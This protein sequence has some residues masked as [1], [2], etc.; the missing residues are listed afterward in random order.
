MTTRGFFKHFPP[1]AFLQMHA[2]G[3]DIADE[4][5]RFIDLVPAPKCLALR[6]YG[7]KKLPKGVV[8]SGYINDAKTLTAALLELK[9]EHNLS[10]VR[11]S[12]PEEKGY[13]FQM[14]VPTVNDGEISENI[15][16]HIEENVPVSP[17]D[18]I[19]DYEIVE[20]KE[21]ETVVS[22]T[23][24]PSKVV[25]A[26]LEVY[27]NAGLTV[28]SFE[29]EGKAIS[30][31]VVKRHEPGTVLI[32]NFTEQRT[33][34]FIVS[35]SIVRFTSTLA[36]GGE[37]I[38]SAFEKNFS[39]SHEEAQKMKFTAKEDEAANE[40]ADY[41]LNT[42][43]AIRDEINRVLVYWQ[44]HS[45]SNKKIEKIL[46]CGQNS[47]FAG[48]DSYLAMGLKIPIFK[49][50]VWVNAFDFEEC[51]PTMKADMSLNYAVPIGVALD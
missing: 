12:L 38:T 13:L 35:D 30:R 22:V 46:L 44:T 40:P 28:L 27:K 8:D 51:V 6:G 15:E 18:A 2:V 49:A 5:V 31:A 26:Y 19:F 33:G 39:I 20:R 45:E 10:F 37:S 21:K 14:A 43:A 4:A 3:M 42:L 50:N 23:V 32:V 41:T 24:F 48:F 34:L 7:E 17:R 16:F 25:N 1:P 9:K 36:I 47:T 11:A 29:T